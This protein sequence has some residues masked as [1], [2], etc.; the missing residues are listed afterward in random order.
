MTEV[1]MLRPAYKQG[2][3]GVPLIQ[4]D[5]TLMTLGTGL[6]SF[7]KSV[8]KIALGQGKT[9]NMEVPLSHHA[10]AYKCCF[11]HRIVVPQQRSHRAS[12]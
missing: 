11:G 4:L 9:A 10:E 8:F 3:F 6:K 7:V 2:L 12:V 1:P 5:L